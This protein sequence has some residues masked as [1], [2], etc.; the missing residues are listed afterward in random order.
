MAEETL[1]FAARSNE[2][3]PDEADA[4][5]A[6][7]V[8]SPFSPIRPRTLHIE[9]MDS[10]EKVA[11][12]SSHN[13]QIPTSPNYLTRTNPSG[14]TLNLED[15]AEDE[16]ETGDGDSKASAAELEELNDAATNIISGCRIISRCFVKLL[17]R[18]RNGLAS[19]RGNSW[20]LEGNE[21]RRR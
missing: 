13:D 14:T 2:G 11:N 12:S 18:S 6:E 15:V 3:T 8:E 16:G 9:D 20:N 10:E 19:F 5:A 17:R 21:F 7:V 4:V 1:Y